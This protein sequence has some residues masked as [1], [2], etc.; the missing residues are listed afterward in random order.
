MITLASSPVAALASAALWVA[1]VVNED[2]KGPTV[3]ESAP[4]L[5]TTYC[6][7]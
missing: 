3:A 7:M 6:G 5:S 4:T 2:N 1:S